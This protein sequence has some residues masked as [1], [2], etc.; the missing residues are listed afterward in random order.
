MNQYSKHSDYIPEK[1]R[2]PHREPKPKQPDKEAMKR[3]LGIADTP[4]DDSIAQLEAK[5]GVKIGLDNV[6]H[7]K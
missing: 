4:Q 7:A 5:R 6:T 3:F 1:F 2:K